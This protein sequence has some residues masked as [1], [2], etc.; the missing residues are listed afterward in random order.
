MPT[1]RPLGLI[2]AMPEE[3]DRLRHHFDTDH[4]ISHGNRSFVP[5]RIGARAVVAVG[6]GIG[7]VNAAIAATILCEIYEV[8]AI[9]FT[10]VAGGL[11]D[12]MSVGDVVI[13]D[14]LIQHDY[15]AMI[16]G[17]IKPY[18]PGVAPLP[19]MEAPVA[20]PVAPELL[21]RVRAAVE[22]VDLPTIQVAG[23]RTPDLHFGPILT[24]DTFMNC[25]ATRDAL[26]AE[27]GGLAIEME[28]AAV[29]QVAAAF[30]VPVVVVRALSDLAGDDSDIS[31]TDFLDDAAAVTARL[32]EA[33]AGIQWSGD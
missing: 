29:G 25:A 3:F 10:G 21:A 2:Y 28:G 16:G 17:R 14:S 7:K 31:F 5:G 27:H 13:A 30:A 33:L 20:I 9:L 18:P 1:S 24:G 12:R 4:A 11:D 26:R 22:T 32:V 19:G 23:D 15:G 8:E 6:C